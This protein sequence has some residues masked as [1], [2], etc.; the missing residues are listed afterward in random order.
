MS[1]DEPKVTEPLAALRK[2]VQNKLTSRGFTEPELSVLVEDSV[3]AT[4]EGHL[5]HGVGSLYILDQL[6]ELRPG[7]GPIGVS[8]GP[9]AGKIEIEAPE[10]LGTLP[11]SVAVESLLAAGESGPAVRIAVVQ[12]RGHRG[13]IG[14]LARPVAQTGRL[15][16][17]WQCT[18]AV[19]RLDG[20]RHPSLGTNPIAVGIPVEGG[21]AII[22]DMGAA[23]PSFAQTYLEAADRAIAGLPME[24]DRT[25]RPR[26]ALAITVKALAQALSVPGQARPGLWTT[27]LVCIGQ[28]VADAVPLAQADRWKRELG[29]LYLPGQRSEHALDEAARNGVRVPVRIMDWL[30]AVDPA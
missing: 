17:V 9:A 25:T 21:G 5:A 6:G 18:D 19:I 14:H 4:A 27:V 23:G 26:I 12:S 15:A 3:L 1:R 22:L 8:G 29:W 7:K 28:G 24:S 30:N 2:R 13:R 20:Q 11:C 10:Y 16:C